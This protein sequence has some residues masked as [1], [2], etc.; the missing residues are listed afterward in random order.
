MSAFSDINDWLYPLGGC[1]YYFSTT[2]NPILYNVMS[3]KYRLAFKKTLYCTPTSP[4]ITRDDLSSMKD[5]TVCRCGSRRGSQL[6]RV[7]SVH[8]QRS[9]KC[10]VSHTSAMLRSPIRLRYDDEDDD[11]S[12]CDMERIPCDVLTPDMQPQDTK[13][14]FVAHSSNGRTKFRSGEETRDGIS[15]IVANETCI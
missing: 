9:I 10:N 12:H 2:V 14:P 8:Y 11:V 4:I 1:L 5:S 15:P 13:S 7:R 3:A 6:I